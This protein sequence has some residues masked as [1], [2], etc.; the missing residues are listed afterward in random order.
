MIRAV[1]SGGGVT[2]ERQRL[3]GRSNIFVVST[4]TSREEHRRWIVKQPHTTWS[5]DDVSNPLSAEQ[6]FDA[7]RRLHEHF[8]G[9]GLPYRVPEPVAFLPEVEAVV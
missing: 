7:L 9:L 6:E 2:V 8:V 5:Q 3:A 4:P 1:G